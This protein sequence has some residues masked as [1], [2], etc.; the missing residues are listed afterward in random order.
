MITRMMAFFL[1]TKGAAK[2][3]ALVKSSDKMLAV[4]H[5]SL[6]SVMKEYKHKVGCSY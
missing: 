1:E 2:A 6:T 3:K 5:G 4:R